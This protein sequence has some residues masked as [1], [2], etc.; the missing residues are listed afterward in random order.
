[1][2]LWRG[3]LGSTKLT[4]EMFA[5]LSCTDIH[6]DAIFLQFE[7]GIGTLKWRLGVQEIPA[8]VS[9]LLRSNGERNWKEYKRRDLSSGNDAHWFHEIMCDKLTC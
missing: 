2:D 3:R 7:I 8:Q 5:G 1:M 9:Y 4:E 6:F